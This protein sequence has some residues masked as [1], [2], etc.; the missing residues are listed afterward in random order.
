ME[1]QPLTLREKQKVF[2]DILKDLDIFC[3]EHNIVYY[4]GCGTLLGAVRHGG[5]IPWDDDLDVFMPHPD[6]I[7]FC[8]E[9]KSDR[10][11]LHTY[12][13]DKSHSFT[14]GLLCDNKVYSISNKT[15]RYNCGIDVYVIYGAPSNPEEQAIHKKEV[16]KYIH[17]KSKLQRIRNG[18][19]N[20]NLWPKKTMGFNLLNKALI[21]ADKEF[22]RYRYEECEYIWPYGGGK[23]NLK[24]ELYGN[25]IRLQ[26]EDGMFNAPSHPQEVLRAGYGDYMTLPPEEK[27]HPIHNGVFYWDD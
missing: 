4:M 16:F 24:K 5:F 22:A 8:K 13:N 18:L 21:R 23:L 20:R 27:R 10:Y 26:F 2:L 11:Q 19:A 25:P 1:K 14:F 12:Q 3:T 17:K 6:Y 7:R 15:K 9:Y